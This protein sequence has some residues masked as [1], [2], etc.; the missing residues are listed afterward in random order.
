MI[1]IGPCFAFLTSDL[2]IKPYSKRPPGDLII[3]QKYLHNTAEFQETHSKD[4]FSFQI[5][6]EFGKI[7]HI[8]VT[9]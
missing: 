4:T 2:K 8:P 5:Q 7:Y 6:Q 9:L 3:K 1:L